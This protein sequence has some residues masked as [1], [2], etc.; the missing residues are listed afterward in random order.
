MAGNELVK[1]KIQELQTKLNSIN[2]ELA[3][4]NMSDAAR[5]ALEE[6]KRAI[7]GEMN[8]LAFNAAFRPGR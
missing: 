7:V 1:I 6:Q 8:S 2:F 5:K 3:N 4:V